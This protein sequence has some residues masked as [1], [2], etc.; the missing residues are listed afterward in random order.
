MPQP[1]VPLA[2]VFNRR[3]PLHICERSPH[4]EQARLAERC[5]PGAGANI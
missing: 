5:P 2:K 4:L 3:E 1:C